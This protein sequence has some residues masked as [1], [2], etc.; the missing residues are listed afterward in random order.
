MKLE[1]LT[2]DKL[3]EIVGK[4]ES[5][6]ASVNGLKADLVK[7]KAKAKG[8]DIDPEEHANLQA[9]VA[10]LTSKLENEGKTSKKEIERLSNLI[11]EKDGA[12]STHLLDAGLT[13]ALVKSK[14]KPELIDAAK[15]LLGKQA[16]IKNNDGKYEAVIGEKALGEYIKEWASSESGK[17]FV[18][19]DSNAGGGANG[20]D[21]GS[22]GKTI[23]RTD[24]DT[25]SHAERANLAKEGFK[26]TD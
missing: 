16:M 24:W 25:K 5:L 6:E 18:A 23:S 9:Q 20:G 19:P 10:E 11:K 7:L 3:D 8:A 2:Q 13:D 1:D 22:Q 4:N 17:H 12:L 14:V 26:V 15:A 21:K